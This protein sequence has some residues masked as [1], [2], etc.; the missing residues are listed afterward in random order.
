MKHARVAGVLNDVWGIESWEQ[1]AGA[2][3]EMKVAEWLGFRVGAS[4]FGAKSNGENGGW[5][6][7]KGAVGEVMGK[8]E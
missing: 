2:N 5:G 3:E 8:G 4:D 7:V 6:G 1:W